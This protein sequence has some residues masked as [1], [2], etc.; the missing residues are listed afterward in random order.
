[1]MRRPPRSTLFPYTT[2]FRSARLVLAQ[3]TRSGLR[4]LL[5]GLLGVGALDADDAR[6]ERALA[7][8]AIGLLARLLA[9]DLPRSAR[10]AGG[11]RLALAL[12][13]LGERRGRRER[14]GRG[15][16]GGAGDDLHT[17]AIAAGPQRGT[18]PASA[19]ARGAAA[20]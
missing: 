5:L 7:L 8:A 13:T 11:L 16:G 20:P 12:R 6:G 3:L 19:S 18:P 10:L 4:A 2:L 15:H 14:E 9:A 1:M 17:P